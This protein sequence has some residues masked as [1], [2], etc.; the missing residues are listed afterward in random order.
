MSSALDGLVR[1]HPEMA[2]AATALRTLATALPEASLPAGVPHLAA[3]EARLAAG[4]AALGGEPLLSTSELLANVHTLA[5]AL[6]A[7]ARAGLPPSVGQQ[8]GE[9]EREGLADAA[10]AGVWDV[11]AALADRIGLEPDAFVT[12]VDHASRPALRS[13]ARTVHDLVLHSRWSRGTC[14]A[15]GAAPL[16]AELRGS[17]AGGGAEQERVLRCGRCLTAW[18]FPRMR[19]VG[20]GE[21]NHQH[22]SYLH[23][24]GEADFRRADVCSACQAYIK[25]IAVL[26]PLTLV[27]ML[28][29]DLATTA[30]DLA[31]VERGF[32]R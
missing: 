14:P 5:A 7:P 26:A 18:P 24:A 10:L 31:A 6:A 2:P 30:L 22:L 29:V 8:I 3:S 16:L 9:A 32:H 28:E 11:V 23:G 21:T 15:C 1:Q 19:C 20:C 25:S 17:G 27:E 4:V 13:G 12:L